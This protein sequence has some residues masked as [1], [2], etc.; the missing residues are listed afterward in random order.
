MGNM[1]DLTDFLVEAKKNTYASSTKKEKPT[2][3]NSKDYAYKKYN[4]YYHDSYLGNNKFIGE[5]LVW[6]DEKIYWGM[7]YKGELLVDEAPNGFSNFLKKS[8]QNVSE[9]SPF[10]GPKYF[11]D[12]AFTYKCT[13][14]GCT[15]SFNGIESI[16]HCGEE[17]YRLYF[18]GGR[19]K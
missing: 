7:N 4:Y 1:I 16:S 6:K 5:E 14:E 18:H 17:I 8:L 19:L 10:R 15:D 12:G 9:K 13:W 3:P 11:E 2:R